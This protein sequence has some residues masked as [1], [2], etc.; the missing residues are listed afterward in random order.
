MTIIVTEALL[1]ARSNLSTP[2]HSVTIIVNVTEIY[3]ENRIRII[4]II[5]TK[6]LALSHYIY[7]FVFIIKGK[8]PKPKDNKM[9]TLTIG[10]IN[11]IVYHASQS[12]SELDA[13]ININTTTQEKIELMKLYN[14]R[15]SDYIDL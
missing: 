7:I 1:T 15:A 13:Q 14:L 11:E 12:N 6:T 5:F 9:R 3:W 10:Q 8:S 4:L 2:K